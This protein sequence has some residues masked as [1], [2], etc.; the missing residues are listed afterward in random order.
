MK[1]R[2]NVVRFS[3][4]IRIINRMRNNVVRTLSKQQAD[5]KKLLGVSLPIKANKE[6]FVPIDKV[7]QHFTTQHSLT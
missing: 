1:S 4:N 6:H 3:S 7:Q 5:N 2:T